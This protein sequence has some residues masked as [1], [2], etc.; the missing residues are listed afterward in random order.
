[1]IVFEEAETGLWDRFFG[2]LIAFLFKSIT[3]IC[4]PIFIFAKFF[5]VVSF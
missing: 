3:I 5:A 4:G 2:A 1:M